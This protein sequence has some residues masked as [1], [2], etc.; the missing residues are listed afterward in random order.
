MKLTRLAITFVLIIFGELSY[1]V[2]ELLYSKNFTEH[3][4]TKTTQNNL[5][6]PH[7]DNDFQDYANESVTTLYRNK[8]LQSRLTF[9]STAT[10]TKEVTTAKEQDC[11]MWKF[12]E[13]FEAT[14]DPLIKLDR[15]LYLYPGLIGGINNQIKG[16]H[17][18]IYL[19]IRLN[20]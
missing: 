1:I 8:A 17:Q 10:T 13:R 9:K 6:K 16:F 5:S 3:W 4:V 15:D 20:R 18:S 12:P 19:A 14:F 7:E 2:F 11:S